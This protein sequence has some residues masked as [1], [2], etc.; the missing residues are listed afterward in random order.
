MTTPHR[1]RAGSAA[2]YL[3]PISSGLLTS[4]REITRALT[5]AL[6]AADYSDCVKDLRRVGIDP[7]S[8]IDGLDKVCPCFTPLPAT[9]HSCPSG[10]RYSFTRIRYLRTMR[11]STQQSL[12]YIRTTPGLARGRIE[13]HSGRTPRCF[14]R[15]LR[16]LEGRRCEWRSVCHKDAASVSEQR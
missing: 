5:N 4:P 8:Y 3:R 12:W 13:P 7:Q 1:P 9:V 14:R 2:G 11:P 6:G 10:D 15:I 16:Y